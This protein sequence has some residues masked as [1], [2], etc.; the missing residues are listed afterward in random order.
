MKRKFTLLLAMLLMLGA[1]SSWAT[2]V[3]TVSDVESWK[4]FVASVKAGDDYSS[5]TV[6]LTADI[7]LP[8]NANNFAIDYMAGGDSSHPFN[9]TF[10]GGGHTIS[11]TKTGLSENYQAL[12]RYVNG[13]TIKNLKTS[14]ELSS[15][16][17]HVAGIVG[18][19]IGAVTLD[20]CS[21]DMTLTS[22]NTSDCRIGGLVARC[23][24]SGASLTVSNCMFNGSISAGQSGRACGIVGWANGTTVNL[25]SCFVNPTSV[26]NGGER[27]SPVR[28]TQT[29]LWFTGSSFTSN[30][31]GTE[32]TEAKLISGEVA[33]DLQNTQTTQYWGQ[34]KLNAFGAETMPKLTSDASCKVVKLTI[35]TTNSGD[36]TAYANKEGV[37]PSPAL[38]NCIGYT[39]TGT[40][41]NGDQTTDALVKAPDADATLYRHFRRFVLHVTSAGATTLILPINTNVLPTGVKAYG[42]TYSSGD[43]VTATPVDKIT[44]NKPVLINAD[45]GDYTFLSNVTD[46]DYGWTWSN[47][48]E[49]GNGALTGIYEDTYV[50][51]DSYVL[52]N[53][54]SGLGFYKVTEANKIKITSFR[55]YLTA[56]TG[57]TPAPRLSIV[58]NN[59]TTG[60]NSVREQ[61]NNDDAIYTL[62][63]VRGSRPTK[64][65]YIKNGK[66]YIVK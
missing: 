10:D 1:G 52:Q 36:K 50:P 27:F 18:N 11:Y 65:I 54:V 38:Y 42:L 57:P 30:T 43:E 55:A 59:N 31:G 17:V 63:G 61:T 48:E 56:Q 37:L 29:N 13:A 14:G 39:T 12:F 8:A 64:G 6:T 21:C 62:N 34:A 9:G 5:T 15:S 32:A 41:S 58:Y 46:H 22:T 60:I 53:G 24:E 7:A 25:S 26:T 33:Y 23:A 44:A 66:K 45:E 19:A 49:K 3:T 2:V 28:N 51:A 40:G 47:I 20:N 35:K 16:G 4:T